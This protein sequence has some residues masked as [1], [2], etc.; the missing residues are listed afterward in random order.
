MCSIS[1]F[2]HTVL[3]SPDTIKNSQNKLNSLLPH[4]N[5]ER[6]TFSSTTTNPL[7]TISPMPTTTCSS[8][9]TCKSPRS[10]SAT[11]IQPSPASSRT[12]KTRASSSTVR[13]SAPFPHSPGSRSYRKPSWQSRQLASNKCKRWR[14]ARAQTRMP[15]RPASFG[16]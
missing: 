15:S 6:S 10:H 3:A 11:T 7:E 1:R 5:Q 9:S 16:T 2:L 14:A 13:H 4:S 12:R 8:T